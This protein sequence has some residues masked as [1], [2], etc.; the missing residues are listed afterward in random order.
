MAKLAIGE[1]EKQLK[2]VLQA[3]TDRPKYELLIRPMKI[4]EVKGR[5]VV[6]GTESDI[7]RDWLIDEFASHIRTALERLLDKSSLEL[8]FEVVEQTE[9]ELEEEPGELPTDLTPPKRRRKGPRLNPRFTF[10][11]FVVDNSNRLAFSSAQ[12]VARQPGGIYNPLFIYSKVGLGK[13]HLLHSIG[14]LAQKLHPGIELVYVPTELFVKE[15]VEHLEK[16]TIYQFNEKYRGC[17]LLLIDD[18]QFLAGKERTQEEFFHTFNALVESQGQIVITSDRAP[19]DL[20]GLDDRLI[21]RFHGGLI[22]D[23]GEPGFE[24]RVAV[25]R[26]KAALEGIELPDKV[27]EFIAENITD[28]I[29][30]LEGA[31]TKLVAH[32]RLAGREIDLELA[33]EVVKDLMPS[34]GG[35]P[36]VSLS[37][38]KS[39]VCELL[40]VDPEILVSRNK[41]KEVA[42]ARMVCMY[43]AREF[44]NL[45]HEQIGREMGGRDHSTVV[46]ACQKI[47]RRIIEEPRVESIINRLRNM[48]R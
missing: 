47:A 8:T 11:N 40:R 6:I 28:N 48:L 24:L 14:H 5:R 10:D 39:A 35:V 41:T 15:F 26:K 23:I 44:T 45:S 42:F 37:T 2:E 43:L 29:R 18:I 27:A 19:Q 36:T 22:C 17:D 1:L 9:E 30:S 16:Q 25:L 33:T 12:S 13:T 46:Y 38:I 31:L 20:E 34:A 4:L 32:S 21:S 7:L 3:T